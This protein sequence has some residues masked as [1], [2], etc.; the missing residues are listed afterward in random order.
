[1]IVL[2]TIGLASIVANLIANENIDPR[3]GY[4]AVFGIAVTL[5]MILRGFT[6]EWGKRQLRVDVAGGK[7]QLP[8]GSLRELDQIGALTMES[9]LMPKSN[10]PRMQQRLTEYRLR[11]AN[12]EYYL[13]YSNYEGETRIRFA[14]VEAAVLQHRLRRVLERPAGDGAFRSAPDPT[15]ELVDIAGTRERAIDGLTALAKSD[16]DRQVRVQATERLAQLSR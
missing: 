6:G 12:V 11:A 8:D 14:A 15:A 7:L 1:M 5:L 3:L 4:L 13:F 16:P 10:N 9:K 2:G